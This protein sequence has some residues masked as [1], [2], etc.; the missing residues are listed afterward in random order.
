LKIHAGTGKIWTFH[1][2]QTRTV[3]LKKVISKYAYQLPVESGQHIFTI[4][5][6]PHNTFHMII[7]TLA[8]TT[9]S[10]QQKQ[11]I[12]Q[13]CHKEGKCTSKEVHR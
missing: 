6:S 9:R 10:P 3:C 7:I 11:Q 2:K 12:R 1:A 8:R 13:E 5:T 4:Q